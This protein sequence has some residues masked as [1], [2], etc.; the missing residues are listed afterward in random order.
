MDARERIKKDEGF[1]F[2]L[3]IDTEGHLTGGYGCK[4][5]K[6]VVIPLAAW[7]IIFAHQ[8]ADALD[9]AEKIIVSTGIRKTDNRIFVLTC[10]TFQLGER[11]VMKFVKFLDALRRDDIEEAKNELRDSD[12][13]RKH[14]ARATRLIDMLD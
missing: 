6:G 3:Y 10:M 14:T 9:Q 11:G 1:K 5:V 7:E 12:W 8:Y 2:S 4:M 13:Y